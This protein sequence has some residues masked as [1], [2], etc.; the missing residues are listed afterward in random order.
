MTVKAVI[1]NAL[2]FKKIIESVKDISNETN[3]FFHEDRVFLQIMDPTHTV[4]SFLEFDKSFFE[5]YVCDN[6]NI[7][8]GLN[9]KHLSM[10]LKCHENN[11]LI[12]LTHDDENADELIIN[13]ISSESD[14]VSKF[15]LFLMHIEQEYL[16]IPDFKDNEDILC[17]ELKSTEI[18]K[19]LSDLNILNDTCSIECIGNEMIFKSCDSD[20][21]KYEVKITHDENLDE[22][23][24]SMYSLPYLNQFMKTSFLND[25]VE[26]VLSKEFPLSIRYNFGPEED[27]FINFFLAPRINDDDV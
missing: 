3:V 1:K 5:E 17:T 7:V 6:N 22:P 21:C 27:S 13:F 10:I 16:E 23:I 20:I 9:L 14:K 18:K 12:I 24:C 8:L 15:H 2:I 4:L 19:I 26:L 25:T 11:E